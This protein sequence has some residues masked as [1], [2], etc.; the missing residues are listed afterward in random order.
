MNLLK[1]LEYFSKINK[2][3]LFW[4]GLFDLNSQT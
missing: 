3:G 1:K 2:V 4:L